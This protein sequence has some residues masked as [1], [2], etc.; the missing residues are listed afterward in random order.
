MNP[1][2]ICSSLAP[3][4]PACPSQVLQIPH[5]EI[6]II[7]IYINRCIMMIDII[8]LLILSSSITMFPYAYD[9]VAELQTSYSKRT[10][11]WIQPHFV[12]G[13]DLYRVNNKN[14][15]DH[16]YG[17]N[18]HLYKKKLQLEIKTA[19]VKLSCLFLIYIEKGNQGT[20]YLLTKEH[21]A[22]ENNQAETVFLLS[23]WQPFPGAQKFSRWL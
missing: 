22:V 20:C 4:P 21:V 19:N 10:L 13:I 18:G 9:F 1:G 6:H 12:H 3:P 16:L 5:M 8:S 7:Y 23:F 14:E 2:H 15:R 11:Y 17:K